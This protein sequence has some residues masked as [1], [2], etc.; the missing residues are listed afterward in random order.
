MYGAIQSGE[1]QFYI[2]EKDKKD[3]LGG[4]AKFTSVWTK[5]DGKWIMS[6]V[7]SYNH[8]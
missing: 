3:V 2:R 5:K 8:Q 1:H 6:D 4:Q 7:L